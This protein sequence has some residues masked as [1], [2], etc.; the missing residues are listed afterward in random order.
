M[1]REEL[2]QVAQNL[3]DRIIAGCMQEKKSPWQT[4]T[5]VYSS[6]NTINRVFGSN[7]QILRRKADCQKGETQ[8]KI[9]SNLGMW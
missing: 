7:L 4:I 9:L 6:M 1:T 2:E 8:W 3:V 5:K